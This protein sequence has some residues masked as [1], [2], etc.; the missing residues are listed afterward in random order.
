M[1]LGEMA[2]ARPVR[3]AGAPSVSFGPVPVTE[4]ASAATGLGTASPAWHHVGPL[5]TVS[6]PGCRSWPP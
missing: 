4:G 2:H 6:V 5:A 1:P 3:P